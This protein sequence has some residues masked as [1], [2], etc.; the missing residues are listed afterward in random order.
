ML[1]HR[2]KKGEK[3]DGHLDQKRK[4]LN[5]LEWSESIFAIGN[6]RIVQPTNQLPNH[7]ILH[8]R[9]V[10]RKAKC[11]RHKNGSTGLADIQSNIWTVAA[12]VL[13]HAR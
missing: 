1:H 4:A 5:G 6:A 13:R 12:P 7:A 10:Q 9:I 8:A 11:T 2:R 3:A